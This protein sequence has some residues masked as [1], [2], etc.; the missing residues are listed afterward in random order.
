MCI[1]MESTALALELII[2]LTEVLVMIAT[3]A[4]QRLERAITE[5]V[6]EM[7]YTVLVFVAM[8]S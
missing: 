5:N 3:L 1:A 6:L 2:F 8:E 7:M 4:I